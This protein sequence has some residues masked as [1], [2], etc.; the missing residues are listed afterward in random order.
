ME[1]RFL[2]RTF[3]LKAH[4]NPTFEDDLIL[5]DLDNTAQGFIK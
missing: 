4:E 2:E 1:S 3:S 5:S